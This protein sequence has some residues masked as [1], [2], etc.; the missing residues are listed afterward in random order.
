MGRYKKPEE[1]VLELNTITPLSWNQILGTLKI[2]DT[3]KYFHKKTTNLRNK[4]VQNHR[5]IYLDS[6]GSTV[7]FLLLIYLFRLYHFVD[8]D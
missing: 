2:V 1:T 5:P 6:G 3:L 8:S 7:C 4:T